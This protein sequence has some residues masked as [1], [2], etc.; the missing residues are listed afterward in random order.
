MMIHERLASAGDCYSRLI[1]NPKMYFQTLTPS[2]L[3]EDMAAV[4]AIFNADTGEALY[5]GRTKRLRRRMYTN[6]LQGNK[7]TAR[8]KKYLV[9]D[10][11]MPEIAT[12]ED[13]KV[14]LKKHCYF[15]FI[16]VA[17]ARERGHTEGLLGYL[18]NARYIEEEH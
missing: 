1:N 15:Q 4:Y 9:E 7:A 13:A 17:D 8:L 2:M 12:Y 14:W 18:L 6:H 16:P 11:D 3:P 5:V 10:D